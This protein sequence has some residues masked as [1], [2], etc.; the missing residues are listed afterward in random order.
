MK[1]LEKKIRSIWIVK[2]LIVSVFLTLFVYI[3]LSLAEP[4]LPLSPGSTAGIL[5]LVSA[6]SSTYY[7]ILKYRAWGFE[8][9]DDHLFL[10]HGVFKKIRSMVPYVRIQHVDTQRGIIERLARLSR[11]VVYTAGSRG[12]DV[13]LPGL[14]I[15]RGQEIQW[16]LRDVAIESE[17]KDGV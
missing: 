11:V 13:T 8:L 6:S 15:S 3:F 14:L 1:R 5:F 12:A 17:E 10:K 2:G 7:M 16:R 9:R 4:D